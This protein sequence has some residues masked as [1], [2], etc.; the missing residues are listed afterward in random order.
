MRR[1]LKSIASV[2]LVLALVGGEVLSRGQSPD[3]EPTPPPVAATAA[4][5][6]YSSLLVEAEDFQFPG[7]WT[8]DLSIMASGGSYLKSVDGGAMAL[9]GITV[10]A[11]GTYQFWTRTR[12]YLGQAGKRRYQ[13]QIDGVPMEKESGMQEH[14]GWIWELVGTRA[15]AA[16][17]H[18]LALDDTGKYWGRCDAIFLTTN[19]SIS[20][21]TI[22]LKQLESFRIKPIAIDVT[23]EGGLP[24][25]PRAS[26]NSP[27][28]KKANLGN[29]KIRIS[30]MVGKDDRGG[31]V[32]FRQTELFADGRWIKLSLA[33]EESLILLSSTD[34]GIHRSYFPTWSKGVARSIK[35]GSKSYD[36]FDV[37]NPFTA[38]VA[39]ALVPGSVRQVD[40]QTVEV[41]YADAAGHKVATQWKLIDDA[42]ALS[43][44]ATYTVSQAG[45]YSL[46]FKAFQTWK[47]G[48]VSFDLLPPN[49]QYQRLPDS[50]NMVTSSMTPQ[51]LVLAQVK[52]PDFSAPVSFALTADP[53]QF[54][55]DWPT[56]GN[57]A[58]GFS[59]LNEVGLI[60][61]TVFSPVL[62]LPSSK[63]KEG[64]TKT[65][66]WNIIMQ[67]GDWRGALATASNQIFKVSDYRHSDGTSLTEAAFNMVDLLKNDEA[68]GWNARLKGFDQIESPETAS[69]SSPL[70][71]MSAALLTRDED[72]Y[73]TRALPS[74]EFVLSRGKAHFA[75]AF[76]V[77][78]GHV[79]AAGVANAKLYLTPAAMKI[80]VPS[81]YYGTSYWQGV[82]ALLGGK[83]AWVRDMA[84]NDGKPR[85]SL[86]FSGVP[87]WS[88]ML[89][90][91]R[92]DPTPERLEAAKEACDVFLKKD[93]YGQK[94]KNIDLLAF[95]NI[96][97]Y[98]YWWDLLDIYECTNDKTYLD[99]AEYCAFLTISQ[100]ASFPFPKDKEVPV[101][102]KT[103]FA[104]PYRMWWKND[105]QYRLGWPPA[106][107]ALPQREA[108]EWV[109]SRVGLGLEAPQTYYNTGDES[110]GR[111][112]L[113]ESWAANL[114]RLY[115]HTGNPI[116]QTYAR[117]A[118]IGRFANYPGYY[119]HGYTDLLR[120]ASYPY[121]GPDITDIYYHHISCQLAMVIDYLVTE[122]S[123]RSKGEISFP[124]AKQ[125]GYGWFSNRVY[126]DAPGSIYGH[127]GMSLWL[128]RAA[129]KVGSDQLDYITAR[130]PDSW[131]IVLMNE[132]DNAVTSPLSVDAKRTGLKDG[133]G[134]SVIADGKTTQMAGAFPGTVTVSAKGLTVVILPA[135]KVQSVISQVAPALEAKPVEQDLGGDWGLLH[136][137]RIRSPFGK[138]SIY[139][140]LTGQ[141]K[142]GAKAELVL[143]GDAGAPHIVDSF[144]YEFSIYPLPQDKDAVFHLKLTDAEGHQSVSSNITLTH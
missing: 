1:I 44:S 143:D 2:S 49:Y 39:S 84:L 127:G 8:R 91:Y 107:Q 61:P 92:L 79:T 15:L 60:Q 6:A 128:D 125:Q 80:T 87:P 36:V 129:V 32:V 73:R 68:S 70:E 140:V 144:P 64:E 30:F 141:P 67:P 135:E 34:S 75:A 51:P 122:S 21:E 4:G 11:A 102:L 134:Y 99:A 43:V 20:P 133:A 38:G 27:S 57:A 114:L 101:N 18:C 110:G 112:I 50:P 120:D 88:E 46:V 77:V 10:P 33:D 111:N 28:E 105:T 93:V 90:A 126:G 35:I 104:D 14:D 63:L 22:D 97:F 47:S 45:E 95:A 130:G 100:T 48:D 55:F 83:N 26:A 40:N 116:Y 3:L 66:R 29:E 53:E 117:N 121:K 78:G 142:A 106:E 85:L 16:G 62:G 86:S 71:L 37:N 25:S 74:L 108:P 24:S 72:F 41:D 137:F 138:D 139:V 59:L 109:V 98:P 5:G 12:A 136:A 113:I 123:V 31:P 54:A 89:A 17:D 76:P 118:I 13:L 115:G 42:P 119:I 81:T 56:P 65:V 124:W 52:L 9:T 103:S 131:S 96:S 7:N 94:T 82:D 132:S 19:A 23:S 58:Y 69:Q